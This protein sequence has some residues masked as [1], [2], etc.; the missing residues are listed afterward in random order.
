MVNGE[1]STRLRTNFSSLLSAHLLHKGCMVLI[2]ILLA[3]GLGSHQLGRLLSIVSFVWMFWILIDAGL[4]ELFI[5][6]VATQRGL[7]ASYASHIVGLKARLAVAALALMAGVAWAARPLHGELVLVLLLGLALITES[8]ATLFRAIFRIQERMHWEAALWAIDG[9]L[10]VGVVSVVL[11]TRIPGDP[12]LLVG[13]GWLAVSVLGCSLSA[14]AVRRWWPSHE[15]TEGLK[16]WSV[17]LRRSIPLILVYGLS[18]LSLR[19]M[20]LLVGLFLGHTAAGYF[21]AGERILEAL[22]VI[23]MA[24]A[25]VML[26]VSARLGVSSV[27]V[28]QRVA[29]RALGGLLGVGLLATIALVVAGGTLVN[30]VYGAAF[31]P[32]ALLMSLLGWVTLPVFLKLVL[33]KVLCGLHRQQAVWRWYLVVAVWNVIAAC[34]VIPSHGLRSA[35]GCLLV[36][37]SMNAVGLLWMLRLALTNPQ[38][39]S[40]TQSLLRRTRSAG[41]LMPDVS[42]PLRSG[43]EAEWFAG[44]PKADGGEIVGSL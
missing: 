31:H 33:E 22:L 41:P 10:K 13:M 35:A 17:L 44:R 34:W 6:D 30:L 25:Q 23:P 9:L 29:L 43:H 8:F 7:L 42:V 16:G 4:S 2:A 3:R 27:P 26:P 15:M 19:G 20:I 21:G 39:V 37:E 14:W 5:R 1:R 18:L 12:L 28:L 32:T 24:L 11:L 36:T 40:G 38:P